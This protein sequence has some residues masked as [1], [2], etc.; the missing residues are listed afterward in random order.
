MAISY[1]ESQTLMRDMAFIG[2]VKVAC[3]KFANYIMNE[4]TAT[5]A[6]NTRYRWAQNAMVDSDAVAGKVTPNVVMDSQVQT[7]GAA[8]TDANLQTSVETT[9]NF[10]I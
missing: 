4:P 3:L 5:P 7:D 8:I 10:M 6:H 2:R 1:E 9:L